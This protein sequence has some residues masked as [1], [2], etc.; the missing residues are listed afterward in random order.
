MYITYN[1]GVQHTRLGVKG[2]DSRVD[3]ELGNTT[4]KHSSGVQM[5]EGGGRGRIS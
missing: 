1:T 5:S 4:R 3:T 2:V